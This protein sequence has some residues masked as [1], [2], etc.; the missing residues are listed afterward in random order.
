[1]PGEPPV[2]GA[3]VLLRDRA[4]AGLELDDAVEEKERLAM[5]DDLLDGVAI[6]RQLHAGEDTRKTCQRAP[7]R[8]LVALERTLPLAPVAL[9]VPAVRRLMVTGDELFRDALLA[10]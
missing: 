1:V 6:E 8:G 4:D 5:R 3:H 2:V 7:T 9:R 10:Q